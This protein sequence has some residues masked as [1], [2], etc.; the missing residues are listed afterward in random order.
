MNK[1]ERLK[2]QRAIRRGDKAIDEWI[3]KA[4]ESG[5][6]TR[7]IIFKC[8]VHVIAKQNEYIKK[9]IDAEHKR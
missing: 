9:S 8:V 4:L 7:N 1:K 6:Y 3:D 5:D 2:L